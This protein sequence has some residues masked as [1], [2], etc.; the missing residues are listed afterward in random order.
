MAVGCTLWISSAH[1]RSGLI[2]GSCVQFCCNTT[3][4]GL[5][6]LDGTFE[7][8]YDSGMEGTQLRL[9]AH[10]RPTSH[11]GGAS[12]PVRPIDPP[13]RDAMVSRADELVA[14]LSTAD[15]DGI[16]D[17]NRI[18]RI[19]ALE[20]VKGAAAAAQARL[21]A[22]FAGAQR[23]SMP[24]WTP[25]RLADRSIGSQV[26]LARHESPS[27]GDAH[28]A[29]AEALTG[30]MPH[31]LAALA[32]GEMSEDGAEAVCRATDGIDPALRRRVDAGLS[33]EL[34]RL[35]P[36][37]LADAARRIA[38]AVDGDA[39]T[40]R[41]H[42]A[43]ASRRVTLRSAADGMAYLTLL[44]PM[45]EATGAFHALDAEATSMLGMPYRSGSPSRRSVSWFGSGD[46]VH[47][48]AA[49]R[50]T[51]EGGT[52]TR[53]VASDPA[54]TQVD[55]ARGSG[56]GQDVSPISACLPQAADPG[57]ARA[58]GTRSQMMV[59]V[60]ISRLTGRA[61]GQ[62]VPVEIQLVM[63]DTALHRMPVPGAR[64]ASQKA[65]AATARSLDCAMPGA[66]TAY[67][68]TSQRDPAMASRRPGAS[69][70]A[71][72]GADGTTAERVAPSTPE[73]GRTGRRVATPD[74]PAKVVGSG[75]LPA[76]FAR[77]L[78]RHTLDA[79]SA[80]T[81]R[82]V[83]ASPD[84]VRLLGLEARRHRLR[85]IEGHLDAAPGT[86]GSE[87]D[88]PLLT[89][90]A[91]TQRLF[92]GVLRRL[93]TVRDQDCRTPFCH[94][95]IRAIDHATPARRG[96]PTSA[97]NGRG[98]CDRCNLTKEAPGWKVLAGGPAPPTSTPQTPAPPT[99]RPDQPPWQQ[100][101]DSLLAEDDQP[102]AG[103]PGRHQT[104]VV[105][106]TGHA[107]TSAAPALTELGW[108]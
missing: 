97:E 17:A 46:P 35:G 47:S 57:V 81:V 82:R 89:A 107:Y 2:W 79:G 55:A 51:S 28:L 94:A 84:G 75:W 83:M 66:A 53:P 73:V 101:M 56:P 40:R 68:S 9:E 32:S 31:V 71:N 10:A 86:G 43:V 58:R 103:Q 7:H 106:P 96:G 74:S 30:A 6:D 52:G 16:E 38:S 64:R 54:L 3:L 29:L 14:W 90:D 44:A 8:V 25:R 4:F 100:L 12:V 72:G 26:A 108:L 69:A 22:A 63:T 87:Q 76:G 77:D 78:I 88:I 45:A 37:A 48:A 18:E 60:A 59:D 98:T 23:A 67:A 41:A 33:D 80:V 20:R 24:P 95:A 93:V 39:A 61:I 13:V 11:V 36:R 70:P 1:C 5:I 105:T 62:P 65:P 27:R 92:R 102:P 99:P 85:D 50:T 42:A 34:G 104:I 19:A 15:G 49:D 21:T 91:T